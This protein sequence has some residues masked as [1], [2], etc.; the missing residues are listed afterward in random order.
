MR[1]LWYE[2]QLRSG[3]GSCKGTGV[4]SFFLRGSPISRSEI[5]S[6]WA[7]LLFYQVISA[8]VHG[9]PTY[10]LKES[11]KPICHKEATKKCID[12]N[13]CSCFERLFFTNLVPQ[14]QLP[15]PGLTFYLWAEKA[16][17]VTLWSSINWWRTL[18]I[19][20]R[21]PKDFN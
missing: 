21:N 13:L 14:K 3:G 7:I 18:W 20:W 6:I 11:E 15:G 19:S 5:K 9:Q 17:R 10:R 16:F 8:T 12:T 2:G 4:M 1:Y